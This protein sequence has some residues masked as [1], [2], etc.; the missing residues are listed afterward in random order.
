MIRDHR[1]KKERSPQY[2]NIYIY[3]STLDNI[4]PQVDYTHSIYKILQ[5]KRKLALTIILSTYLFFY[6]TNATKIDTRVLTL[7]LAETIV[8]SYNMILPHP[9]KPVFLSPFLS[10]LHR[11]LTRIETASNPVLFDL[12]HDNHI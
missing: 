7:V 6:L 4:N 2:I 11:D 8:Y 3:I 12:E 10:V 5:P 9:V 1:N